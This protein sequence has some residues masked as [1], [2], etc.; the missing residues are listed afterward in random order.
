MLWLAWCGLWFFCLGGSAC[1]LLS[2]AAS[3][4][5]L[6]VGLCFG[7]GV[8]SSLAGW[9][10]V[11]GCWLVQWCRSPVFAWFRFLALACLC[12]ALRLGG[13][14]AR[15]FAYPCR[16]Q[17]W[18]VLVT[19][20]ALTVGRLV[21]PLRAH[22]PCNPLW[23]LHAVFALCS[24]TFVPAVVVPDGAQRALVTHGVFVLRNPGRVRCFLA[25]LLSTFIVLVQFGDCGLSLGFALVACPCDLPP[26]L[27]ALCPSDGAACPCDSPSVL[28]RRRFAVP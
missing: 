13:G 11:V 14:L 19:C 18:L 26:P 2:R 6:P 8:L 24:Q 7:P 17:V 16:L 4:L 15:L 27:V 1:G 9:S 10:G 28:Q 22:R 5:G 21:V 12:A 20:P 25:E 23:L 3:A